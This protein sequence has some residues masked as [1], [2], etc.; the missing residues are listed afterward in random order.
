[1]LEEFGKSYLYFVTSADIVAKKRSIFGQGGSSS[2]GALL[3][4]GGPKQ[5][6][7]KL[8]AYIASQMQAG[9]LRRADPD[10]AALH[11]QGLLEAGIVEPGLFGVPPRLTIEDAVPVAIR[12]FML[13]Y[14]QDSAQG[15]DRQA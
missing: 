6:L 10:I 11:L 8:A 12:A 15:L 14:G 9:V 13:I 4:A 2:V 1:V 7:G 3:Y 5:T